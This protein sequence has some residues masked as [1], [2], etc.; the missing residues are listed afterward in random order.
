MHIGM[1][2]VYICHSI[3]SAVSSQYSFRSILV[4]KQLITWC[5]QIHLSYC[6]EGQCH[7]RFCTEF[8]R[9]NIL[10]KRTSW[11]VIENMLA[12]LGKAGYFTT[13]DLKSKFWQTPLKD[14]DKEKPLGAIKFVWVHC[15]TI[16]VNESSWYI[17][18]MD[19][20]SSFW[21]GW[22][23]YGLFRWHHH[24]EFNFIRTHKTHSEG[25]WSLAVFNA[26]YFNSTV[27]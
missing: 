20:C 11:P 16:W 13:L 21:I 2:D 5:K 3:C 17:P 12:A 7:Y 10:V 15:L 26:W 18:A 23:C 1:S 19:V 4:I 9:L 22:L 27:I 24:I 25:I 6:K 14:E 8:W